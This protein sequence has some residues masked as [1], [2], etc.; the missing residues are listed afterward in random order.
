MSRTGPPK[1]RFSTSKTAPSR[2]ELVSSGQNRRKFCWRA[3]RRNMSR[4][5]IPSRRVDS[6]CSVAGRGTGNAYSVKSGRSRSMSSFPPFACGLALMRRSPVGAS[7]ASAGTRRGEV[8]V[9]AR[10]IVAGDEVDVVAVAAQQAPYRLVALT[11]EDG[12][13]GDL[14]SVQVEDRQHRTVPRRVEEVDALPR[15]LERPRL[16]LAVS[17]HGDRKE[18]RI[19]EGGAEGM[20]EDVAELAALVDGAG[21]RH[22]HVARHASRRRELAEEPLHALG[23]PS[24]RGV[25]LAVGALEVRVREE[26]RAPVTGPGQVD[27]VRADVPD[28][29]VQMDV[30]QAQAGRRAPVPEEPGLDVLGPQ[31]LAEKRVLLEIYLSDGEVVRGAPVGV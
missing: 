25:D 16:G 21:R 30:D 29:A 13:A 26:S 27:D 24:D 6:W 9:D 4:R 31:R 8:A 3:L 14:V 10:R 12:R 28:Q 7:A 2:F 1:Q 15:A 18:V 17:D 19:V 20:H 23:V 5:S 11:T 22:A